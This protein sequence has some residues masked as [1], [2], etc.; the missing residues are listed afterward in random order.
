MNLLSSFM[1]IIA[2][3]LLISCLLLQ[4]QGGLRLDR[5]SRYLLGWLLGTFL[6]SVLASIYRR[7]VDPILFDNAGMDLLVD[8]LEFLVPI[9]FLLFI[10]AYAQSRLSEK[11]V[12]KNREYQALIRNLPGVSYRS[13]GDQDARLEHISENISSLLGLSAEEILQRRHPSLLEFLHPEDRDSIL[14]IYLEA[15]QQRKPFT[16]EYRLFNSA[17]DIIWVVD[18]GQP[19]EAPDG[20]AVYVDGI[21]LDSTRMVTAEQALS[22]REERMQAQQGALLALSEFSGSL[23]SAMQQVTRLMAQTLGVSRAGVWLFSQDKSR[24]VCLD[25]YSADEDSHLDEDELLVANY[26]GYFSFME[27]GDVVATS[28]AQSNEKTRELTPSYLAPRDIVSMMDTPIK[29]DGEVRGIV[30]AENKYETRHWTIDERNFARSISNVVSLLLEISVNRQIEEDLRKERDRAQSYL[31]TVNVMIV[32]I[33]SEGFVKLVNNRCCEL[34][35]YAP[36]EIEGKHWFENFVPEN[37]RVQLNELFLET[38]DSVNNVVSSF[39]NHVVTKDGRELLIRW[40]NVYQYDDE[41]KIDSILGAGEDITELTRQREDK[42][43][44][45]EEMQNVQRMHSIVQLTGGIAH[46]FNNM[47]TSIMGYA[48]LAQIAI[49]RNAEVESDRYLGAIRATSKK[50]GKL[51]SQL[52]DYSRENVLSKEPMDLNEVVNDSQRMLQAMISSSIQLITEL[53]AELPEVVANKPQIQQV[54]M[55]LCQNAKEALKSNDASIWLKTGVRQLQNARCDSCFQSIDGRYACLEVVDN[56]IGID[57][58]IRKTIFDPFTGTKELGEGA[59]LGLS[60]THGIVHMHDGHIQVNSEDDRTCFRILFPL[61]VIDTNEQEAVAT[62][63]AA[64][65]FTDSSKPRVLIVDDDESVTRLMTNYLE[66]KGIDSHAINNSENAWD[67]FAQNSAAF[68][69]VITDQTMPNLSGLELARRIRDKR[70]DIPVVLCS[71]NNEMVDEQAAAELGV[72]RFLDKPVRLENLS[73]MISELTGSQRQ[74][75]S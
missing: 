64:P 62:P 32:S 45:Q 9:F 47:L 29:I 3:C 17:G 6:V 13:S 58:T 34:L 42:A 56:G 70:R 27:L 5:Y 23:E 15:I 40:N 49:K 21:I 14:P 31:D 46:D 51:V 61:D 43:R 24:I 75:E 67:V 73:S 50:A 36:E 57:P 1:D 63:A 22:E 30:C 53:D 7:H 65:A 48:D 25:L 60:A 68:D 66:R 72:S 28:S 10:I 44:L 37:E 38:E 2:A 12:R 4:R 69:I 20:K 59:G 54:L 35:G 55:N 74:S 33:D 52:L 8:T 11:I 18:R 19:I 16:L 41:G 39:E 71:G 26:P